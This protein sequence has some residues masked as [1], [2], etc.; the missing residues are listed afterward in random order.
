MV[1]PAQ[2]HTN[3]KFHPGDQVIFTPIL[4]RD[5]KI[6]VYFMEIPAQGHK[7]RKFLAEDKAIFAP[8]LVR[9]NEISGHLMEINAHGHGEDVKSCSLAFT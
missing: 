8:I 7:N 1:I 2:G 6:R 5:N 9:D 3:C 4:V